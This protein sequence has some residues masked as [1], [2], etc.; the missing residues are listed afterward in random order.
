M[1]A[2]RREGQMRGF[3]GES[4]NLKLPDFPPSCES[5]RERHEK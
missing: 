1:K 3:A 5:L 2:G 4:S